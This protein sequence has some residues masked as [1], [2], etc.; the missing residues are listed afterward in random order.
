MK[1]ETR[2]WG[3]RSNSLD[4]SYVKG[5]RGGRAYF[6]GCNLE[7]LADTAKLIINDEQEVICALSFGTINFDLQ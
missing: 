6:K 5:I 7:T 1:R 4:H 3:D 2:E